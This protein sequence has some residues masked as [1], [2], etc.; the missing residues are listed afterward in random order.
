MNSLIKS[1]TIIYVKKITHTVV[2]T[3]VNFVKLLE[4]AYTHDKG[5]VI[6]YYLSIA[7][8]AIA[9]VGAALA[10]RAVIDSL[11]A[12]Y[13]TTITII[14]AIGIYYLWRYVEDVVYWGL[15]TSYYDYLLRNKLQNILTLLFCQKKNSLDVEYLENADIQ[16]ELTK[17]EQ[18]YQWQLPDALRVGGYLFRHLVGGL[19]VAI[20]LLSIKWWVVILILLLAIPRIYFKVKHG[21]FVWSMYGSGAPETK[22]LWYFGDLLTDKDAIMEMRIF[23]SSGAVLE[24]FK[25]TQNHLFNINRKPL[26]N[27][28]IMTLVFPTLEIAITAII[29]AIVLPQTINGSL[30]VGTFILLLTTMEQLKGHV[31]WG[32]INVGELYEKTLYIKPYFQ[33][34]SLKP[35]VKQKKNSLTITPVR[36]PTIEFRN[37]SFVY[38]HG[39][40]V[41]KNISFTIEPQE[42][43]AFV[44]ENG[45]GKSTLIKLLCRFYDVTSGQILINGNDIK[46]LNLNN[47]YAH[48]GTLFQDFV[49]YN[50][51]VRENIQLGLPRVQDQQ[52]MYHAARQSGSLD[53]IESL[54]KKFDQV[55]GRQFESGDELSGGQ[56]QKLAIARAFY[57]SAPILIMDEP[58]SAIDAQAEF[59]IFQN[60]EKIYSDK[61]LILVSHRFSTVRNAKKIIVLDQGTIQEMG[62]HDQL[63]ASQGLYHKMFT[64][65]AKG[66]Q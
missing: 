64:V 45:A 42:S 4:V 10:L 16:T 11:N 38:P 47:W 2:E 25:Q 21:N 44:G 54:P 20:T 55:L 33:I 60:L 7:L 23:Q 57:E 19:A 36:P 9:P 59:E 58:T 52:R 61:T 49:K 56:W 26:D 18:S 5:L 51:T 34:L 32:A 30:S 1:C 15:N 17:V 65:Q 22:K 40:E 37:V 6:K 24:K 50:F 12:V 39:R 48:L 66:Y 8:G 63:I 35:K 53:F 41:L 29:I 14:V 28:K 46:D 3:I 13:A 27:Y 62:T 43:V 31:S